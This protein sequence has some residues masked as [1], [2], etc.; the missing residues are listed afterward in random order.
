MFFSF[1]KIPHHSVYGLIPSVI[2]DGELREGER[3]RGG[4]GYFLYFSLSQ[5]SVDDDTRNQPIDAGTPQKL[6]P[7]QSVKL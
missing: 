5:L 4:V 2:V 7:I 3:E 6:L 1:L